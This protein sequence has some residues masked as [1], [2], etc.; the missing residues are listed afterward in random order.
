MKPTVPGYEITGILGHGSYGVVYRAIQTSLEREVA[1]KVLLPGIEPERTEL[2]RFR[3]EAR[4]HQRLSHPH[5]VKVYDAGEAEGCTYL[6]ME[7]MEGGSLARRLQTRVR[8]P[9]DLIVRLAST[10]ADGLAYLHGEGILHRDLKPGNIL[11]GARGELK[12]ADLGLA[13]ADVE[14]LLTQD[15]ELIGTI[16]YMAPECLSRGPPSPAS[17]VYALGLVLWELILGRP[18]IRASN[19]REII[20]EISG[21]T[22]LTPRAV[23]GTDLPHDFDHL[24]HSMIAKDP[25]ARPDA[26]T[27]RDRLAGLAAGK[28]IASD[29]LVSGGPPGS[30]PAGEPTLTAPV[31]PSAPTEGAS[32]TRRP[33]RA[34]GAAARPPPARRGRGF[35]EAALLFAGV[36]VI[37]ITYRHH[38]TRVPALAVVP[39]SPSGAQDPVATVS[40]AP[41][42]EEAANLL[43]RYERT[44]PPYPMHGVGDIL[45][46]VPGIG[47]FRDEPGDL[48]LLFSAISRLVDA[49]SLGDEKGLTGAVWIELELTSYEILIEAT[50]S[51]GFEQKSPIAGP[52]LALDRQLARTGGDRWRHWVGQMH[53]AQRRY[54]R[55]TIQE[56]VGPLIDLEHALLAD[57]DP[58]LAEWRRSPSGRAVFLEHLARFG[59][60]MQIA[61]RL[62]VAQV[63]TRIQQ[64]LD[65][66]RLLFR[67]QLA[68]RRPGEDLGPFRAHIDI[69]TMV[70]LGSRAGEL[71]PGTRER[72]DL[73]KVLA[74]VV[75]TVDFTK[76]RPS[77]AIRSRAE[78]APWLEDD[79]SGANELPAAIRERLRLGLAPR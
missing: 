75:G 17:D 53:D 41:L 73:V 33:R 23:T 71:A 43:E 8:M 45:E 46:D 42:L 51:V 69:R 37:S 35:L 67:E 1:L 65:W 5:V 20:E 24:L 19:I 74:S 22:A 49:V 50:Q 61:S 25:A 79:G 15:R 7:V 56:N 48:P 32:A 76:L 62:T 34:T 66:Y 55:A 40:M 31:D 39:P 21:P 27:C 3:R 52:L 60:F 58:A 12:L 63:S 9:L 77:W 68:M 6:A 30:S 28:V 16:L 78:L 59:S 2:L 44:C 18:V 36:I 38:A 70:L 54:V 57:Q 64:E 13:R 72:D 29:F 26:P 11:I 47:H 4:L 14:T 10:L